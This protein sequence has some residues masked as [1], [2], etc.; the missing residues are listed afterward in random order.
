MNYWPTAEE[1]NMAVGT[2]GLFLFAG[3]TAYLIWQFKSF[4]KKQ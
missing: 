4:F 2:V 1:A 3:T